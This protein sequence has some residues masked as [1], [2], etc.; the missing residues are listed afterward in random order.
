MDLL[1][2]TLEFGS[3]F[4]TLYTGEVRVV[5]VLELIAS[6]PVTDA[7]IYAYRAACQYMS[8][9]KHILKNGKHFLEQVP[10]PEYAALYAKLHGDFTILPPSLANKL[11]GDLNNM[12]HLLERMSLLC[13]SLPVFFINDDFMY[14]NDAI[15]CRTIQRSDLYAMI[16][17]TDKAPSVSRFINHDYLTMI[18]L[19]PPV[20][21]DE[22]LDRAELLSS[23]APQY[24]E[25]VAKPYYAISIRSTL[26]T[27]GIKFSYP[28][29]MRLIK[30]FPNLL[31]SWYS[32]LSEE[33]WSLLSLTAIQRAYCLGFQ[34]EDGEVSESELK[35]AMLTLSTKG[36][37]SYCQLVSARN[38][39]QTKNCY[40]TH[41]QQ[42]T[43]VNEEDT[44]CEKPEDYSPFDIA[45]LRQGKHL[46]RFTRPEFKTLI[47]SKVNP[48]NKEQLPVLFL[49]QLYNKLSMATIAQLPDPAPI[50]ELLS[51]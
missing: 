45:C 46:F 15:A 11:I 4:D 42:V 27:D 3:F 19:Y 26:L 37:D 44:L 49:L 14:I 36:I 48:W 38:L 41:L 28:Q 8:P 1:E 31:P 9:S 20:Y 29:A 51:R 7:T 2:Q 10:Y 40:H 17:M 23:K 33:A 25:R 21:Q 34:I 22:L 13:T 6:K 24:W 50:K 5:D 16:E 47:D 12:P 30:L 43:I 35:E 39:E 18:S 32:D